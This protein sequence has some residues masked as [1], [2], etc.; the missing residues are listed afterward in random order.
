M[1][2]PR[3][4]QVRE[5]GTMTEPDTPES[6]EARLVPVLGSAAA[7]MNRQ[8]AE[9][10]IDALEDALRDLNDAKTALRA[11]MR[12]VDGNTLK[13]EQERDEA[14]AE[15]DQLR[16]VVDAAKKLQG[17]IGL[18]NC[19]FDNPCFQDG[20]DL[21]KKHLKRFEDA[22]DALDGTDP[23]DGGAP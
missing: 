6:L 2:T 13:A 8:V 12:G 20:M 23:E 17:R 9:D 5:G 3:M 19:D 4:H 16:E 15:R 18:A 11:N 7:A 22:L 14:R 1:G 10:A 21:F